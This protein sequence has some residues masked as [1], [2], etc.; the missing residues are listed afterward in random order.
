M[1]FQ[2]TFFSLKTITV[3]DKES[4]EKIP[5]VP[6]LISYREDNQQLYVSQ[7]SQWKALGSE[8]KVG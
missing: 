1:N 5:N 8:E 7:G 4:F 3:S 6:G 2:N